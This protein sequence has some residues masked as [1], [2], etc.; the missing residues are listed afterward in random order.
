MDDKTGRIRALNDA[1]RTS[2]QGGTVVVTRGIAAL[3]DLT[4]LAVLAAVQAFAG[5][6][7]GNDPHGEHDCG[8][9]HVDGQ[10]VLWKVDYYD[11]S[12]SGHS[13][14]PADPDATWRVL[15]IMLADEY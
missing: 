3:P 13:D 11:P 6:D 9:L 10:R 2:G 15:T 7:A 4:R 8:L 12:M 1:L 14:D 5:F